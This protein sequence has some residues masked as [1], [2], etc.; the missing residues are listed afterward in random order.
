MA[1]AFKIFVGNLIFKFLTHTFIL[2]KFTEFARTVPVFCFKPR[3][4]LLYYG[5]IWIKNDFHN[6]LLQ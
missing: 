1:K 3:L 6:T 4:N 5:F 2:F